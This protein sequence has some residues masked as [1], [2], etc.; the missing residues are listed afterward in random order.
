[1]LPGLK[2][3]TYRISRTSR[4]DIADLRSAV[5]TGFLEA[6]A[7]IDPDSSN[8]GSALYWSS[9]RAGRAAARAHIRELPTDDIE[10]AAAPQPESAIAAH[11]AT[12]APH[13][14]R[15]TRSQVEGERRG[16]RLLGDVAIDA[17]PFLGGQARTAQGD[18]AE[19][20]V[21]DRLEGEAAAAEEAAA[22]PGRARF[23]R[24]PGRGRNP[25]GH[26]RLGGQD[27]R[28]RALLDRRRRDQALLRQGRL[29]RGKQGEVGE[30]AH[31]GSI[32][33]LD[34]GLR[35]CR[36]G[37]GPAAPR[38]PQDAETDAEQREGAGLRGAVDGLDGREV[39]RGKRVVAR[40]P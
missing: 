37:A 27:R 28:D 30:G 9:Y 7:T 13:S 38:R 25:A 31:E 15:P 23:M 19:R 36:S 39:G 6:L 8:L 33:G 18:D 21:R 1:M 12:P 20:R 11:G 14:T 40:N 32:L 5:V 26:G 35:Q 29:D 16:R 2:S 4:L 10:R 22:D 24:L 17:N 34:Q 3:A